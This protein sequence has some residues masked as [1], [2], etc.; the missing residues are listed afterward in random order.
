[1]GEFYVYEHWRPDTDICFYV[2]KGKR[3][4]AL[5]LGHRNAEHGKII[6]ELGNKGMC[7]EV[8]M[9]ASG[10]EEHDAFKI[11]RSRIQ[12]WRGLGVELSNRTDGGEGYSG[13]IRP[14][15]IKVSEAAKLKMSAA[16]KRIKEPSS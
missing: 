12:F 5:N 10:L 7:A 6:A 13:F 8:R 16:R 4:R 3:R 2:G 14:L 11:E 9:F 15:G 1:M